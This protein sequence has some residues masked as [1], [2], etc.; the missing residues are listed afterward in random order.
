MK[1]TLLNLT[2]SNFAYEAAFAFAFLTATT[3]ADSPALDESSTKGVTPFT[4]K[5]SPPAA[6]TESTTSPAFA[7]LRMM[8]ANDCDA[9]YPI[10][11]MPNSWVHMSLVGPRPRMQSEENQSGFRLRLSVEPGLTGLWQI[12]GQNLV[13]PTDAEE[14]DDYYIDHWSFLM[15]IQISAKT[16]TAIRNGLGA[17]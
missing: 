11:F 10:N 7:A 9:R 17:R 2:P 4:C 6:I 5:L 1:V 12:S 16:F 3:R 15:D 14:L 8:I 13:S